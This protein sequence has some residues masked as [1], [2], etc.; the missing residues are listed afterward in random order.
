M[1]DLG[2][3]DIIGKDH[4]FPD[5]DHALEWAEDKLIEKALMEEWLKREELSIRDL[6]VF[7]NLSQEQLDLVQKY[8]QPMTFES[9]EIIFNEGDPGDG[10]YFILS[11]YTSVFIDLEGN[12]RVR[13][14]ATFSAG[15][16]FGDMAI[17]EDQPRSATVRSETPTKLLFLS[18]ENFN[19]LTKTEPLVATEM[20]LGIARE[21]SH[22]L[23]L[24]NAEVIALAE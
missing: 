15:V 18:K 21:L 1:G 2:I 3:P 17:L 16:F 4:I 5:T 14:L 24:T 8:M 11:G 23:R 13:R 19:K 10:M 7:K 20:L 22:R 9:E 6:T 12:T